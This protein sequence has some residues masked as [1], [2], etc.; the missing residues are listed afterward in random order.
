[1]AA[2]DSP[3]GLSAELAT[4][5]LW[6]AVQTLFARKRPNNFLRR[7][8]N[9]SRRR[10][11]LLGPLQQKRGSTGL[12]RPL[13]PIY[14]RNVPTFITALVVTFVVVSMGFVLVALTRPT[15]TQSVAASF[16]IGGTTVVVGRSIAIWRQFF[17]AGGYEEHSPRSVL[18]NPAKY[19]FVLGVLFI[20]FLGLESGGAETP[21]VSP[22]LAVV[23][24][25]IG[26]LGYDVRTLQLARNPQ[27]RSWFAK[28]YGSQKSE[29]SP[30]PVTMPDSS[31]KARFSMSR[32]TALIDALGSGVRYVFWNG[33]VTAVLGLLVALGIIAESSGILLSVGALAILLGSVRS[34]TRYLRYGTLEYRCYTD[35]LVVFDRLLGE[36][37]SKVAVGDV[38]GVTVTQDRVDERLSTETLD[39]EVTNPPEV[40]EIQML[41]PPPEEV[42]TSDIANQSVPL[43]VRHLSNAGAVLECLGLSET[44]GQQSTN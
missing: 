7:A 22:R 38:A 35:Q 1:M 29:I 36:P 13:P 33:E 28:L 37:Q 34:L 4:I 5:C 40:P 41:A 6:A 27:R 9:D 19:L 32:S 42:K 24:L 3:V 10:F 15:I 44:R 18:L 17:S 16:L 14:L 25:A 23:G 20:V 8:L 11:E 2:R 43:T 31:P 12:A 39:F 30:E 26:K 21:L